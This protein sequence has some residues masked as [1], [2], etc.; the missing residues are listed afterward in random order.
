MNPAAFTPACCKAG[1]ARFVGAGC[2]FC[3]AAARAFS[4][5]VHGARSITAAASLHTCKTYYLNY[6][7]LLL[8]HSTAQ[9]H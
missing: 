3:H 8:G 1:W 2:Y 5:P 4:K 6:L 7:T 9:L